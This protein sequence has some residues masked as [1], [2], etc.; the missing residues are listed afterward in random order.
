MSCSTRFW[1]STELARWAFPDVDF[2]EKSESIW[3]P[4]GPNRSPFHGRKPSSIRESARSVSL[5]ARIRRAFA[6]SPVHSATPQAAGFRNCQNRL[7][8]VDP[9]S[10][11]RGPSSTALDHLHQRVGAVLGVSRLKDFVLH[12]PRLTLL[13]SLGVAKVDPF[14]LMRIA[15]HANIATTSRYV[16]LVESR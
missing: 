9:F 12:S 3:A 5:A 15:G 7:D 4:F 16:H 1:S 8:G 13:T 11:N 6:T 2:L 10:R 14:T